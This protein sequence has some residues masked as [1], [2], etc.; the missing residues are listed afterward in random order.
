MA[1]WIFATCYIS[2]T[3]ASLVAQMVKCLPA[4][5]ETRFDL[6]VGKIPWR[7]KWQLLP[8]KFQGQRSPVGYSPW[9]CKESDMTE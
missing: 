3:R 6:W 9:G 5:W 8:E 2:K 4:M 1:S 7:R